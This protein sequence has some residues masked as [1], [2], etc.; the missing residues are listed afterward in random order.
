[1]S[2]FMYTHTFINEVQSL[3]WSCRIPAHQSEGT[4]AFREGYHWIYYFYTLTIKK[5]FHIIK[6]FHHAP[7]PHHINQLGYNKLY[8]YMIYK[9]FT[10]RGVSLSIEG[11]ML[12]MLLSMTS[13]KR[14]HFSHLSVQSATSFKAPRH[15]PRALSTH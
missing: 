1:M 11:N 8:L 7:S 5:W 6:I 2:Y 15:L 9:I 4:H 14:H 12:L 3:L 13:S 10:L